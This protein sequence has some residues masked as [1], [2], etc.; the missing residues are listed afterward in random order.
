[1]AKLVTPLWAWDRWIGDL[2]DTSLFAPPYPPEILDGI[3]GCSIR[4]YLAW[5]LAYKPIRGGSLVASLRTTLMGSTRSSRSVEYVEQFTTALREVQILIALL[6]VGYFAV[7][8]NGSER[9]ALVSSALVA[10]TS[11]IAR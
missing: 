5:Q 7:K 3:I 10:V 9:I 4:R 6:L 1:L 2:A 8:T 11:L